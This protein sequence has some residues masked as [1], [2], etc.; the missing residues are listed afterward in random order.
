[1]LPLGKGR[2]AG[3]FQHNLDAKK[4][5]TVPSKWRFEG[6]EKVQYLA[7]ANPAGCVT[8]YPPERVEKLEALLDEQSMFDPEEQEAMMGFFE[9]SSF[10]GCD[11]SGRIALSDDL[12]EHA[13]LDKEVTLVGMIN[14]F[15][16]WAPDRYE[17]MRSVQSAEKRNQ[18]LRKMGF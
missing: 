13:G 8:L 6:D 14:Q 17:N 9:M 1:M 18:T 12:L 16:I 10:V 2:F 5:L 7:V 15:H 3:R 11:K 4:R